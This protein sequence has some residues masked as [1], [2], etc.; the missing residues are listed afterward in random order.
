MPDFLPQRGVYPNGAYAFD[1]LETINKYNGILTYS[2]PI[3]SMPL[4]RGGMTVPVKLVYSSAL[5]DYFQERCR[6]N[7]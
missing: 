3:T 6:D 4:G 7:R 1:K 5:A 2:I